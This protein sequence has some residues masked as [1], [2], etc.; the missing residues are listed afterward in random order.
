MID[1]SF[2]AQSHLMVNVNRIGLYATAIAGILVS[3][4]IRDA[5]YGKLSLNVE[6][7]AE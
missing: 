6:L 7:Q 3:D 1:L 5:S 4:D 2:T